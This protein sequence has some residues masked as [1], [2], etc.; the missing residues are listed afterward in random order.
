MIDGIVLSVRF[1]K[2]IADFVSRGE[3]I[4]KR[5]NKYVYSFGALL[6]ALMMMVGCENEVTTGY[7]DI[8]DSLGIS[9]PV[10]P[11]VESIVSLTPAVT[12]ILVD[13]GLADYIVATDTHSAIQFNELSDLAT[14]DLFSIE[15]ESMI[16][17][18][19]DL[20]IAH[21]MIMIGDTGNDPL[22]PLCDLEI[23]VAYLQAATSIEDIVRDI[24]LLGKLTRRTD[25]ASKL[26][27]EFEAELDEIAHLLLESNTN[28]TVYFEISPAPDMFT[29]GSETFQQELLEIVGAVNV[30]ANEE[31]WFQVES[32]RVVITNPDVIFTSVGFVDDPTGEILSRAGW[33][34]MDAIINGR[35]YYIDENASSIPN[36]NVVVAL[37][38]MANYLHGE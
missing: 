28:P 7:L 21:D 2:I 31:G 22:E 16:E 33:Q 37:R 19:P 34:E 36:H 25:E 9:V 18:N 26:I 8:E 10:P 5:L 32:E 24:D 12:G 35:V 30:F 6:F 13:L 38:M 29:F 11:E 14:F 1:E 27:A 15:M 23:A 17:L 4:M 20:V 3:T